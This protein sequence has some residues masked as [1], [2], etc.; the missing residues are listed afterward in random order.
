MAL[1]ENVLYSYAEIK[2]YAHK[3]AEGKV[4]YTLEINLTN[5]PQKVAELISKKTTELKTAIGNYE[6]MKRYY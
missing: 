1:I 4:Y 6:S 3:N 2:S 5:V